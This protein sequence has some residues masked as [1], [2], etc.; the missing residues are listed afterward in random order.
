MP[1]KTS[2][3]NVTLGFL[4][5][6]VTAG[7]FTYAAAV[8][9]MQQKLFT[10]SQAKPCAQIYDAADHLKNVDQD[11]F[12][13]QKKVLAET[14]E[15]NRALRA[16]LSQDKANQAAQPMNAP[17]A[18]NPPIPGSVTVIFERTNRQVDVNLSLKF[19]GLPLANLPRFQVGPQGQLIPHWVFSGIVTPLVAGDDG[20]AIYYFFY[21]G[22]WNGPYPPQNVLQAQ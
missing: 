9:P 12:D 18:Q 21:N 17:P 16:Q 11:V 4:V 3:Q 15:E 19:H 2:L 6:L 14:I 1:D 10:Y 20:G 13:T 8:M 5:G 22:Q 7:V